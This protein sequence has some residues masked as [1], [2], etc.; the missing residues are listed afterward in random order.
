MK[1]S[2]YLDD[3]KGDVLACQCGCGFGSRLRHWGDGQLAALH[4]EIRRRVGAP[5]YVLSGA[6][7]PRHNRAVAITERSQHS[8]ACALD[9]ATPVGWQYDDF[10][11]LC[12]EVVTALTNGQGGVGRYSADGFVHIDTGYG[13]EAGRRWGR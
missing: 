8:I 5:V 10:Y 7:C 2:E 6:R 11:T 13:E 3:M 1:L 9:L 12:D 4:T